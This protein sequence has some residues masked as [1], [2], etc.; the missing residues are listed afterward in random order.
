[1]P[2]M[3]NEEELRDVLRKRIF[4]VGGRSKYGKLVNVGPGDLQKMIDGDRKFT[5]KVLKALGYRSVLM[6]ETF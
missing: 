6:Y 3:I 4:A 1:M 5:P 2:T